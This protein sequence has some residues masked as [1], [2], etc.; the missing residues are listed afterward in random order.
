MASRLKLHES[1]RRVGIGLAALGLF[2]FVWWLSPGLPVLIGPWAWE[3]EKQRGG[4]LFAHQWQ[5]HDSLAGGDGLGPVYN[6]TSCATCHFQGGLGGAGAD[7]GDVRVYHVR[8]VRAGEEPQHGMVHFASTDKAYLETSEVL[9]KAFPVLKGRTIRREPDGN[10]CGPYTITIPD[11]DPLRQ[12]VIHATPLFG[13][14]WIDLIPAK[15][16][17]HQQMTQT[18]EG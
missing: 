6:A 15:A 18:F 13:A 9:R 1:R 7:K 8:P 17:K 5:A 4:D 2:S 12:E 16:I 14:G 11:F 10:H 3:G